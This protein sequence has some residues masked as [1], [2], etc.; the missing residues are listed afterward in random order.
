MAYTF[1]RNKENTQHMPLNP[2]T[3]KKIREQIINELTTGSRTGLF[4][5]GLIEDKVFTRAEVPAL[6]K[7]IVGEGQI[8]ILNPDEISLPDKEIA[9]ERGSR[10][11]ELL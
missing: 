2:E 10:F 5:Q 8:R 3:A 1:G 6:M 4:I 9:F 7:H 11:S